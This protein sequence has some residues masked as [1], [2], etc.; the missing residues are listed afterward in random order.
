MIRVNISL[1]NRIYDKLKKPFIAESYAKN[2]G[3]N[4]YIVVFTEIRRDVKHI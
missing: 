4:L 3:M 2:P 1:G